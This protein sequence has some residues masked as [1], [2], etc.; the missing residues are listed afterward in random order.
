MSNSCGCGC[1]CCEESAQNVKICTSAISA[2][3]IWGAIKVRLG[4][5]R[6]NYKIEPGLYAIGKPENDSPVFVS[7]NYKLTFDAL[8]KNLPGLDCW[9]LI[10]DTN[11]INV[12][13]AAGK[14]TFGT[15]E[16]IER[17]DQTGLSEIVTHRRL[18]LPQLGASGVIAHEV[19]RETGFDVIYGPV[20]SRDIKAF[21]SSGYKA[22]QEMRT[23]N[24]MFW[25][26]LA[27]TPVELVEALKKSLLVFGVLFLLNLIAKRPFGVYDFTIYIG[28]VLAGTVI[29]PGLLPLIPGRAFS[30]KGWLTG[31]CWTAFAVW[32][33]GW[34]A[35]GYRL[36]AAG[37]ILLLPSLSAYIAMN[38]TGCSTYTSPSGVLKE[39]KIALPFIIGSAVI[40]SILVLLQALLVG[41]PL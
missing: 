10:L 41:R 16:I 38:F 6:M 3:D 31:L 7:A 32:L 40:G 25:D 1:S 17:I 20:R 5:R 19:K 30:W 13:C 39:M 34:F 28:A 24:F 37:Y 29:T 2:K 9:I 15:E 36:L 14:G 11:G 26:R 18:I 21:I 8:R 27:L 4:I 22:T 23:V 33:F 35:S 12:W